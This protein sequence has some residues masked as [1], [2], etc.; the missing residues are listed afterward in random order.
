MNDQPTPFRLRRLIRRARFAAL[1]GAALA[2]LCA[3][4]FFAAVRWWP[5]PDELRHAPA[6]STLVLDRT[7]EP[8]AAFAAPD[9]QWRMPLAERDINPHLLDAVVAVEDARFFEHAGV[10]WRAGFAAAWQNVSSFHIRRGASTLTMQ[11]HRLRDPRPRSFWAKL[12]QTI[13][14]KQIEGHTS[15]RDILVEYL[16]RAPFGGNLVGAGAASWR[17]FGKPCANLSLG[18]CALLAGL[19]QSPNRHRPDRHLERAARRR[20]V[21][22]DRMLACGMITGAQH[23]Q[24]RHEPVWA[25]WHVLPQ[26]GHDDG[27]LPTFVTL[28]DIGQDDAGVVKTSLDARVQRQ[29]AA[30]TR[31]HLDRLRASGVSSAAIVVLDSATSECLAAVSLSDASKR[32]DLTRRP[33]S[34][35]SVLKPFIYAAAFEAGTCSASTI[36]DDSPAAWPG[37]MPED[38]DHA[39]KG[40]M[41]AADALAESRNIPAMVVLARTG[42]AHTIG[43]MQ[44]AGLQT[45]G[46]SR[47][48][49]GLSLA[50]GGAEATPMEVA[51]AYAGLARGGV[52]SPASFSLNPPPIEARF[53]SAD[54]CWSV[55][56][57]LSDPDRTADVCPEAARLNAAW[58]TGTSGGN[59]DAWC[60]AV[61]PRRT[62]VVWMGNPRGEGSHALVGR[63]VA[64]PLALGLIAA[65]DPT[66]AAWPK[67]ATGNGPTPIARRPLRSRFAIVSPAPDRQILLSGD[68]PADRQRVPLQAAGT[69]SPGEIHWFIDGEHLGAASP[70]APMFWS[71]QSGRHEI[72]AVAPDGRAASVAVSVIGG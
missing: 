17:Y 59:R 24:A 14:A 33:R 68:V 53:V 54:A 56:N 43:L 21:V 12:E 67:A 57:A 3:G 35:G 22:L 32:V 58:K 25:R 31:D 9:G 7:G 38:Y 5:Y 15:K 63:D 66:P 39:F 2:A 30:A 40:Q 72:R 69:Q 44:S 36:L 70:A 6:P 71:P 47:R 52:G 49:Y 50:V 26:D 65:L 27:S 29:V 10:D 60:A 4:A 48:E 42:I 64:A 18:E 8:L 11:L 46:A 37:Y 51:A 61:T 34:T 55:L 16:N 23:D 13:R 28:S 45:L 1:G 41:T 19:P 62:I 20:D